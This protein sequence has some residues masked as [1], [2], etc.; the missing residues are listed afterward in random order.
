MTLSASFTVNGVANPA[1]HSAS[2]SSTVALALV[3]TTGAGAILWEVIACSKSGATLP[4]ITRSGTPNGA[5]GSFVL[6]SDPGDGLGRAYLVKCSVSDTRMTAVEYAVVGAVNAAGLLPIVPGEENARDATHGWSQ[7]VN[8]ALASTATPVP[9]TL[10]SPVA[11]IAALKAVGASDRVDNQSR[12]VGSPAQVWI[13]SST[14]GAGFASDDLTVVR[15]TDVL[16]ASNGRWYPA[17]PSA[18]VPTIAALRLAV[19]GTQLCIHTQAY[20]SKGD[21]GGGIFD[22]VTGVLTDADDGGIF[23][24]AGARIFKRRYEGKINGHWFGMVGD[25]SDLSSVSIT[26]GTKVVTSTPSIVT[27]DIGKKILIAGAGVAGAPLLATID[28]AGHIDTNASTTVSGGR[29]SYGTDNTAAM[30]L[31]EAVLQTKAAATLYIPAAR[32]NGKTYCL[33]DSIP[34]TIAYNLEGD[35]RA[36]SVLQYIGATAKKIIK[37]TGGGTYSAAVK[38]IG[39]KC[40]TNFQNTEF[41]YIEDAAYGAIEDVA[42]YMPNDFT[43]GNNQCIGFHFKNTTTGHIPP[44][45]N[46]QL[47]GVLVTAETDTNTGAGSRGIWF[48]GIAGEPWA[49][50]NLLGQVNVEQCEVGLF[51]QHCSNVVYS[52]VGPI[53]GNAFNIRLENCDNVLLIAPV[54]ANTKETLAGITFTANA[55]T[56][57]FTAVAHGLED[58]QTVRVTNSGGALPT[59]L[60][61]GTDYYVYNV[62]A[63]TFQLSATRT[64]WPHRGVA[65]INITTNGT[66]TQTLHARSQIFISSTCTHVLVFQPAFQ[67]PNTWDNLSA[68][69]MVQSTGESVQT[70]INSASFGFTSTFDGYS[71]GGRTNA[72]HLIKNGNA[73]NN[74]SANTATPHTHNRNTTVNGQ[75]IEV[76]ELNSAVKSFRSV[77]YVGNRQYAALGFFQWYTGS[78]DYSTYGMNLSS[79]GLRVDAVAGS[80]AAARLDVRTAATGDIG[81]LVRAFAGQTA[82]LFLAQN[83]GGGTIANVTKDGFY[84]ASD[85]AF[86][87]PGYSFVLDTD[88]GMFR[89]AADTLD[90]A[91]GGVIGAEFSA[92]ADTETAMLVRRNVGGSFTLQRVSMGVADSGGSGFKVLRVPN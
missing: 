83:S 13:F 18:V 25:G 47:E 48:E 59:G 42:C 8:Q 19:S 44:R 22:D 69:T 80:A 76:D 68:S 67:N 50:I 30:L 55:G 2:Y 63:D 87:G 91:I 6:P 90:F 81:I 85:G 51:F 70:R 88:T 57:T 82:N 60:V 31:A 14:T 27:A 7:T 84:G 46:F 20:A 77:D 33:T 86:G 34:A 16:L 45:G 74:V 4:S 38:H 17:S 5:T 23:I 56:D 61:A 43:I 40:V 15:P 75:N 72:T 79:T 62:T 78:I 66:G 12:A 49:S 89:S 64:E 3:S 24:H 37:W 65:A 41:F 35:G 9:T 32:A 71:S 73:D 1:A 26:S 92:P 54:C 52:A 29:A 21:G 58:G 53:Q 39:F 36:T 10:G 28:A 11:N